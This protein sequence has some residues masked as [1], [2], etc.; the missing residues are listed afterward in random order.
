MPTQADISAQLIQALAVTEPSLDTTI[1]SPIRSIFDVV[2]E[3]V[4]EDAVVEETVAEES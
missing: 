1:G 2:A 4:A 3:V